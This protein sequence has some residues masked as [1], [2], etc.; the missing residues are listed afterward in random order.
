MDYIHSMEFRPTRKMK[1]AIIGIQ[2]TKKRTIRLEI[3]RKIKITGTIS[4]TESI[5]SAN[6]N[7]FKFK[8]YRLPWT[9]CAG[10]RKE[11]T[12]ALRILSIMSGKRSNRKFKSW[13][14]KRAMHLKPT[15]GL[16]VTVTILWSK[17][18]G[19]GTFF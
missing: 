10:K 18:D 7:E 9:R 4:I 16:T 15:S 13:M 5:P 3:H 11:K 12:S 1:C 17:S 8:K 14:K 2:I 6:L 19:P